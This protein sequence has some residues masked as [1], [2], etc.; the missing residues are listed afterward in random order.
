MPL[1]VQHSAYA[2][3]GAME[4]FLFLTALVEAL[5][6]FLNILAAILRVR[7]QLTIQITPLFLEGG[8]P[9]IGLPIE[10]VPSIR[11]AARG[12]VPNGSGPFGPWL[13]QWFR[14][15]GLSV[16]FVHGLR[17]F[18]AGWLWKNNPVYRITQMP[19]EANNSSA[20][21]TGST[22]SG[23][24]FKSALRE[25]LRGGLFAAAGDHCSRK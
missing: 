22:Y 12:E 11:R 9:L 24:A 1:K 6:D 14:D 15:A 5:A 4:V 3:R 20:S 2:I 19:A 13:R 17:L 18:G 7:K 16:S 23:R 8:D 10:F 25:K 21:A